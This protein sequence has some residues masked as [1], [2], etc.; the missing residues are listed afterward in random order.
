MVRLRLLGA[1]LLALGL[2]AVWQRTF[3][4]VPTDL[5]NFQ[6]HKAQDRLA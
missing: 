3:A 2:L 5:T 1:A 6:V 4:A